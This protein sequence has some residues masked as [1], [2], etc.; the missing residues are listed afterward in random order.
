[1]LLD[2][3]RP[4][5]YPVCLNEIIV[6]WYDRVICSVLELESEVYIIKSIVAWD[7]RKKCGVGVYFLADK[8]LFESVKSTIGSSWDSAREHIVE[9]VANYNGL[10]VISVEDDST[11][12]AIRQV[13]W[14]NV[15]FPPIQLCDIDA[16]MNNPNIS[17]LEKIVA[18]S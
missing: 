10:V 6:E 17:R 13:T 4:G 7:L 14:P 8:S 1:M 16:A 2:S 9:Y 18:D 15:S 3:L 12:I 5:T 11:L